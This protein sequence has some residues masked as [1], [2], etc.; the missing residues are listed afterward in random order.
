[1]SRTRRIIANAAILFVI[2]VTAV[3]VLTSFWQI[4]TWNN[5][6]EP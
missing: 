6:S 3:V 4:A 5:G 2:S 1:V